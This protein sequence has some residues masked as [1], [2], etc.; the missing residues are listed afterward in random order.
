MAESVF[1][2]GLGQSQSKHSASV[3]Y[4]TGFS[5]WSL[6]PPACAAR[7]SGWQQLQGL[8]FGRRVTLQSR[9]TH[10]GSNSDK[11]EGDVCRNWPRRFCFLWWENKLKISLLRNN[12]STHL[13][14]HLLSVWWDRGPGLAAGCST[15]STDTLNIYKL[16]FQGSCPAPGPPHWIIQGVFLPHGPPQRVR[17]QKNAKKK[18]A[19]A[20]KRQKEREKNSSYLVSNSEKSEEKLAKCKFFTGADLI[21]HVCLSTVAVKNVVL[22][23]FEW[24][25]RKKDLTLLNLCLMHASPCGIHCRRCFSQEAPRS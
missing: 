2:T 23:W 9:E 6:Q 25:G 21:S 15:S 20:A 18:S 7:C 1:R 11:G 17:L 24:G 8:W 12:N 5:S 14:L 19:C 22:F 13:E 10:S 4:R 3:I 16:A